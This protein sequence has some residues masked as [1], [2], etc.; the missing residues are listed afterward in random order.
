MLRES[1][2]LSQRS[3]MRHGRLIVLLLVFCGGDL[4]AGDEPAASETEPLIL[5]VSVGDVRQELQITEASKFSSVTETEHGRLSA[6][7]RIGTL[8]DG[9]LPINVKTLWQHHDGSGFAGGENDQEIHLGQIVS[10]GGAIVQSGIAPTFWIRRGVDPVPTLVAA[11]R[12]RDSTS[13]GAA[14]RLGELGRAASEAVPELTAALD[15]TAPARLRERAAEA[16]GKIGP[17]AIK[18]VPE[19]VNLIQDKPPDRVRVAAA[20]ALW[21]IANHSEATSSL[22]S[23]MEDSDRVVRVKALEALTKIA[24]E[25]P[26]VGQKMLV[27]L[28]DMDG[29]I[30]AAAAY[31]LWLSERDERAVDVLIEMLE[32]RLRGYQAAIEP[33]GKI[34]YPAAH[35]ATPALAAVALDSHPYWRSTIGKIIAQ[36]DPGGGASLP[37]LLDVIRK[38]DGQ[39]VTEASEILAPMGPSLFPA[40]Q[41]LLNQK[42][43]AGRRLALST[44]GNMGLPA[45]G[46][47]AEALRHADPTVRKSAAEEL[48]TV[49]YD[50]VGIGNFRYPPKKQGAMEKLRSLQATA[51]PAIRALVL[52]LDDDV[53]EVRTAASFALMDVGPHAIPAVSAALN[54]DNPRAR[55]SAAS[56]IE[57]IQEVEQ[58]DAE[59]DRD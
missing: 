27:P 6:A 48:R 42:E 7:G 21:Q 19:L 59:A 52:A 29:H 26:G 41:N 56:I 16:L 53:E 36:V 5:E 4:V 47:L 15:D 30:R 10:G 35:R 57:H 55:E 34:G 8:R 14:R 2:R 46:M 18:A 1:R 43:P 9:K 25:A 33:L 40:L 28:E 12:R 38:S 24:A 22:V 37:Y 51:A 50:H 54:S 3:V 32:G 17:A 58:M 45:A 20:L 49:M 44:L 31:V 11:L 13:D 39:R 23:A